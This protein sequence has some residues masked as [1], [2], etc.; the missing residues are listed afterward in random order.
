MRT[1]FPL[2]VLTAEDVTIPWPAKKECFPNG[3]GEK[4]YPARASDHIDKTSATFFPKFLFPYDFN[5]P[6]GGINFYVMP[7]FY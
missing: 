3:S 7:R 5:N 6:C 4:A 1:L 2:F